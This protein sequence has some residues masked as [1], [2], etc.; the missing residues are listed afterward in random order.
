M[1]W[2]LVTMA[3][4]QQI[5]LRMLHTKLF[6]F[7]FEAINEG[8]NEIET[9]DNHI[10]KIPSCKSESGSINTVAKFEM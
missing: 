4:N 2:I 7:Q 8:F 5:T 3:V 6:F 10:S 9:Y 1:L